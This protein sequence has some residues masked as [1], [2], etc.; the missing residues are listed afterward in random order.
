MY[1]KE[2][3]AAIE[4]GLKAKEK[5]YEYTKNKVKN[6]NWRPYYNGIVENIDNI[7]VDYSIATK[8]SS[9]EILDCLFE[10]GADNKDSVFYDTY[11][12]MKINM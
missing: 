9:E 3:E 4:A 6:E 10:V 7:I 1:Q 11:N 2:L 5:I 8:M 12:T